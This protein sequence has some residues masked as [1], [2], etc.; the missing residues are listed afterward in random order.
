MS[1][2][3]KF[4]FRAKLRFDLPDNIRLLL[5]N[6]FQPH[7]AGEAMHQRLLRSEHGASA[8]V[9][10]PRYPG[11]HRV[12]DDY[13]CPYYQDQRWIGHSEHLFFTQSRADS[14]PWSSNGEDYPKPSYREYPDG[15]SIL[16]FT[17]EFNQAGPVIE[18]F[19]DWI[20]PYVRLKF[21]KRRRGRDKVYIGYRSPESGNGQ[22]AMFIKSVPTP[23]AP[24]CLFGREVVDN[25]QSF[26]SY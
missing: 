15:S 2:Y 25:W 10:S 26:S 6:Q 20:M 22:V 9:A 18:D 21:A 3:T 1:Y 8:A 7:E 17:C 13:Q 5:R 4:H 16:E 24:Y 12:G 23:E 11:M 19:L 14:I